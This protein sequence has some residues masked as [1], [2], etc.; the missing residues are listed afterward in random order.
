MM[1]PAYNAE[2]AI[3]IYISTLRNLLPAAAEI[4]DVWN[5]FFDHLA[6]NPDFLDASEPC[7]SA[8][9]ESKIELAARSK[10]RSLASG[11]RTR[12]HPRFLF[13][14]RLRHNRSLFPAH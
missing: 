10:A 12:P 9:L 13:R 8:D 6:T 1:S 2:V 5:Y 4:S 7:K 3:H 14:G 11:A